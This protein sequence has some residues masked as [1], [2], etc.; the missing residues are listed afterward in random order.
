MAKDDY[1]VIAYRILAYLYACLKAG[2]QVDISYITAQSDA[3][4]I[5]QNY[6]E[7]I[8]RHLYEDGYIDGITLLPITGRESTLF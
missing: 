8:M 1:Y 5:S 3:I 2:E 6:W 4:N 7:Y